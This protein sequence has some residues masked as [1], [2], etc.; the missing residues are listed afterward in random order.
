MRLTTDPAFFDKGSADVIYVDYANICNVVSVGS[1]IYV[2]DG[3]ISL[4]AVEIGD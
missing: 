4:V 2:D 3:L 1:R